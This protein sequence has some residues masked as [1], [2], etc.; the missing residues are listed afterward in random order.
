MKTKT[1]KIK[2][3]S[4]VSFQ[5]R[6]TK[7]VLEA[8]NHE[9]KSIDPKDVITFAS[10][11]AYQKFMTEQK[12]AILA[13]VHNLKPASLYQLAKFVDRDFANLKRDCESLEIMGFIQLVG[14]GNAKG[15]IIPKL[16]FDYDEIEI[17]MPNMFY[18][19][20]LGNAAA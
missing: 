8:V 9:K 18:S 4:W 5:A 16:I 6:A 11:A 10:V 2:F 12:Y 7:A 13:A 14:S 3:E 19:H 20:H 1:L 15:A 17:Q